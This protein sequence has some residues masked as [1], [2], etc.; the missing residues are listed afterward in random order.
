MGVTPALIA[1]LVG[2]AATAASTGY[3]LSKGAPKLPKLEAP[4]APPPP[5]PPPAPLPEPAEVSAENP[6]TQRRRRRTTAFG[7][8]Q[9]ILGGLGGTMPPGATGA[10]GSTRTLLGG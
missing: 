9:T 6:V 4:G 1:A 5:P 7:I 2:T 8:E 3:A 10:G